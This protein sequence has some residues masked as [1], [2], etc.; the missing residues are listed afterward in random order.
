MTLTII[1]C[2]EGEWY[3]HLIGYKF[4]PDLP[5]NCEKKLITGYIQLKNNFEKIGCAILTEDTDY[6]KVMRKKKLSKINES[7]LSRI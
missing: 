2:N 7:N 3:S 4:I 6:K 5:F 1:K